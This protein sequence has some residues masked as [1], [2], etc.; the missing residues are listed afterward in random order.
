MGS[1]LA[2]RE[3][4]RVRALALSGHKR[5]MFPTLLDDAN[6]SIWH[7]RYNAVHR[8]A[9]QDIFPH[10]SHE[11]RPGVVSFTATCWRKLLKAR[12]MPARPRSSRWAWRA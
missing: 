12:N 10:L 1:A 8:G 11:N 4:G 9:E 6:W 2:L 3:R 7:L 5:S